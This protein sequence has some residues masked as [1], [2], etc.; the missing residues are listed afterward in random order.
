MVAV[1]EP[2]RD[3]AAGCAGSDGGRRFSMLPPGGGVG[4]TG[5]VGLTGWVIR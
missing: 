5:C 1:A 4:A 2:D 3:G